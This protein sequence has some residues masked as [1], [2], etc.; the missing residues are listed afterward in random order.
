[1]ILIILALVDIHTLFVLLFHNY[2][3]T[4]YVLSGSTLAIMKG[5]TFFIPSRD[6]FSLIDIIVGVLMLILLLGEMWGIFFWPIL[7]YLLYKI[8]L[9]FMHA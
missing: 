9:S 8:I 1:M 3:S 6:L 5:L 2:L 4:I 7:I